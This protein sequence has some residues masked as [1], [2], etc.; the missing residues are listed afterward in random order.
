MDVRCGF[1]KQFLKGHL[2][3][4]YVSQ[5]ALKEGN[6]LEF[7]MHFGCGIFVHN[8]IDKDE[9]PMA[10]FKAIEQDS[11]YWVNW[12]SFFLSMN[13][14]AEFNFHSVDMVQMIFGEVRDFD[15]KFNEIK[16]FKGEHEVASEEKLYQ[17]K[18]DNFKNQLK[19][20]PFLSVVK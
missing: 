15:I 13:G 6:R 1:N 2:E 7:A 5:I 17:E 11:K 20:L 10:L 16:V 4:V 18:L 14:A 8:S 12:R 9:G 19:S 3:D